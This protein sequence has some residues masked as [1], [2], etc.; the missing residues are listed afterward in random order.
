MK[1]G[2]TAEALRGCRLAQHLLLVIARPV[3]SGCTYPGSCGE[4]AVLRGL[5]EPIMQRG[6]SGRPAGPA[7][8]AESSADV[9]A[10]T[11]A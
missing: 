11:G 10:E 8:D 6:A 2:E 5:Q 1:A 3:L 9:T 4:G 7:E